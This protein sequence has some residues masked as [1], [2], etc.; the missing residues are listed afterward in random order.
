MCQELL[1]EIGTEEIP[2]AFLPKAMKDLGDMARREFEACR[3][4]HGEIR[5]MAA[6]RRLVLVVFD[7][8]GRQEDLH[9]EKTGP[10]R[11][12]AFDAE[13]RPTKAALGFARGQGVELS[14]VQT[15]VTDKGE[16][17][18]VRKTIPGE[19]TEALLPDLLPRLILG[20]PFKK[21][22]RWS[23][24][25]IRYA[26]PI[27]WL[28]ALYGGRVVPFTI[29]NITS[30]NRTRGHRFM[31]PD[32]FPVL[33]FNDYLARTKE[34]YVIADP[35]ERKALILE[36]TRKA[37]ARVSGRVL[38]DE[39]LLEQVAFLTEFPT[40][41][42]GSFDREFLRLPQEVLVTSMISHQKYFPVVDEDGRLLPHFLA[43]NNTLARDPSVVARG[44]EKVIR[45][46]LSDAHFFFTEDQ[47]IPLMDRV[48]GL[49]RVV[50]HT[51]LGTSFEKVMRFKD[52]A[53][54]LAERIDPA[55][56][57]TVS[58]V[59]LLAKADLDTQMVG[60]FSELQG[61]MGREYALI[62]GEAPEVARAIYEHYLPTQAGGALPATD[63]GAIV[64]IADKM[65]TIAGFF[66][67]NLIPTGTAD[68]YALRRQALGIIHIILAKG[69]SAPLED[70]VDR[71]LALLGAKAKR[72]TAEIRADILEFFRGRLEN[73]LI[74]Q[75]APYDVVDAVLAAGFSDLVRTSKRIAAMTAF[76]DHAD[77][78]PLAVAFKR[79][80]NILK[81]FEAGEV[82]ESLLDLPE[83]K[84][85]HRAYL[86]VRARAAGRLEADDY[87]AALIEMA[88]I[89]PPVDA[90]F[91]TVLVMAE[92]ERIRNNRLSLLAEISA[93]LR[94]VADF[95]RIVTEH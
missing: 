49:K 2:A 7:L 14:E 72:P 70:L 69:Y 44:N 64:S 89:R 12:A 88:K 66:A 33:D 46:R 78:E 80:K 24:L 17:L 91:E 10:A 62:A 41:V 43:V 92:D 4:A 83:E 82:Q 75:G 86:D 50:Y 67:V 61:V 5:T 19:R 71:S 81:D 42:C 77:F 28:L 32:A 53:L 29:G 57:D 11:K 27:H 54:Y 84:A 95:A 8:A 60:E 63:A 31:S 93:L 94:R 3:L 21:S 68:P 36:E 90:F 85:L 1:L 55:L 87:A 15:A 79:V 9:V 73:L 48:E 30:G 40:V 16:Y 52:L 45:A 25:D 37:A 22:M 34:R 6:P 65:D 47:K 35:A 26:R 13:G 18:C 74:A 51:Q 38:E 23:D 39:A 76:K 58:R 20:I 59:A 56:K